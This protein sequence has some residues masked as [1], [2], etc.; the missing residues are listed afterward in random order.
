MIRDRGVPRVGRIVRA[1]IVDGRGCATAVGQAAHPA[2]AVPAL[3]PPPVGVGTGGGRL[4]A[5]A[6][7]SVLGADVLGR[8]S[9]GS[10]GVRKRSWNSMGAE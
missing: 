1:L 4:G 9:Y 5:V 6:A 7:G 2:A 3:A 10:L 8:C